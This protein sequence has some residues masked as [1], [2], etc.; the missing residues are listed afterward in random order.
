MAAATHPRSLLR[1]YERCLGRGTGFRR[2]TGHA[3]APP[4]GQ[5]AAGSVGAYACRNTAGSRLKYRG[6]SAQPAG[7]QEWSGRGFRIDIAAFNQQLPSALEWRVRICL[8]RFVPTRA[9][10]T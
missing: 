4:A 6:V 7:L 9:W 2:R 8:L 3:R 5:W 1:L 10:E